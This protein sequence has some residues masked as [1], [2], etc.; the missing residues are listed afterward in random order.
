MSAFSPLQARPMSGQVAH[1]HQL[2]E[3]GSLSRLGQCML[4]KHI[5]PVDDS[6][7]QDIQSHRDAIEQSFRDLEIFR[8]QKEALEVPITS[9]SMLAE[10]QKSISDLLFAQSS[11]SGSVKD[12]YRLQS[13]EREPNSQE[14]HGN[15]QQLKENQRIYDTH[16]VPQFEV[17]HSNSSGKLVSRKLYNPINEKSPSQVTDP[18]FRR[19]HS[20]T[21]STTVSIDLIIQPNPYP[22]STSGDWGDQF[23]RRSDV[24]RI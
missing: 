5:Y 13:D 20:M 12:G 22:I 23:F 24:D 6:Y 3:A 19:Y 9:S 18:F 15:S 14:I 16:A 4:C 17:H 21:V 8:G 1:R 7:S 2:E 11:G 10:Y